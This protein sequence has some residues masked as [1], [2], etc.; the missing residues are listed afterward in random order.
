MEN[1]TTARDIQAIWEEQIEDYAEE[2]GIS[3]GKAAR[4]LELRAEEGRVA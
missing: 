1:T 2:H 4:E 3:Y